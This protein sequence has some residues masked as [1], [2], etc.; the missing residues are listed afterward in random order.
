MKRI[1]LLISLLLL[2]PVIC[3]RVVVS[4]F[5]QMLTQ[6]PQDIYMTVR[7]DSSS[8]L[9]NLVIVFDDTGDIVWASDERKFNAPAEALLPSHQY[10]VTLGTCTTL[11]TTQILLS[12]KAFYFVDG[13]LEEEELRFTISPQMKNKE[14]YR[15]VLALPVIFLGA[16]LLGL[17]FLA[18]AVFAWKKRE[19]TFEEEPEAEEEEP[20]GILYTDSSFDL[21]IH[22]EAFKKMLSNALEF[23]GRNLETM[24]FL[25]GDRFS[26]SGEE[27]TV[28]RD[29]VSG[30]LDATPSSVRFERQG[31]KTLFE[32]LDAMGEYV[33]LGWY[34]SHPG[35]G[36]FMSSVDMQTQSE[37]FRERY[38][39]AIVVDPV[40][41]DFRVFRVDEGRLYEKSFKVFF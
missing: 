35:Y 10:T 5:P 37:M 11:S 9:T 31:F 27:Y 19:Q 3:Q 41:R 29:V 21:Y 30:E 6:I 16:G 18:L 39:V 17:F 33:L 12:G 28:V 40:N 38:H 2:S 1:L 7:N 8:T 13:V 32:Q 15:E 26:F 22:E 4:V 34:H 25:V 14:E 36:C 23:A 20:A 24:G